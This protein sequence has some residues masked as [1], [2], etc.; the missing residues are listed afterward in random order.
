MDVPRAELMTRLY[1]APKLALLLTITQLVKPLC[2]VFKLANGSLALR[3]VE[4]DGRL[5][6]C[7]HHRPKVIIMM[8]RSPD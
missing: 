4:R 1:S 6:N 8:K 5:A 3:Q 7:G 2:K